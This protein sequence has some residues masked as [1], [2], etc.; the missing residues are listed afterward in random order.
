MTIPGGGELIVILVI[1]IL[2]FGA[3]KLPELGGSVGKSIK[4]FKRGIAEA[5]DEDGR[6][7]QDRPSSS[8]EVQ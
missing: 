3:K 7:T 5:D 8:R 6:A 4:S 1:V 2:L